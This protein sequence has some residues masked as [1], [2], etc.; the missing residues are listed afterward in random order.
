[1]WY[2]TSSSESVLDILLS[3]SSFEGFFESREELKLG[4]VIDPELH[5]LFNLFSVRTF[6]RAKTANI[7][8]LENMRQM[9]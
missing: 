1:M 9:K 5:E 7:K 3:E 6:E 2:K 8:Q 4:D